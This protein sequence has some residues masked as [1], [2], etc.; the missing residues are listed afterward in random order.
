M[1]ADRNMWSVGEWLLTTPNVVA[2]FVL[3]LVVPSLVWMVLG[4]PRDRYGIPVLYRTNQGRSFPYIGH[5]LTFLYYP[6]WDLLTMW[7]QQ[8]GQPI[9]CFPLMG[10]MMFSIASPTLCKNVL[11]SKVSHLHKDVHGTM[12]PFLS[13]LGTGIV[14]S[15][16]EHWFQQRL[17][18]SHPLRRDILDIIPIQTLNAVQRLFTI[19][20]S[21]VGNESSSAPTALPLGSLLRHLTLQVISGSF[22]S[23]SPEQSDDTFAKLY[24]PIVDESKCLAPLSFLF[25][26]TAFVLDVSIQCLSIES[27]C[28][29]ID[30][31]AMDITVSRT[32]RIQDI[33]H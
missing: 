10:S 3:I 18:M 32:Y 30:T 33:T 2:T 22:L 21:A 5:A 7:H 11:Q 16:G 8:E 29:P 9:I 15:D 12:K 31:E 26:S 24:L 14:S 13:I 28:I 27:I 25:I 17:K 20:D 19:M 23:L 6:P 4:P 1:P